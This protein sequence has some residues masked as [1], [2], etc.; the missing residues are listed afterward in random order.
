[1][2]NI[3]VSIFYASFLLTSGS[4]WAASK[5][6]ELPEEEL[7][8]DTALPMFDVTKV[9]RNRYVKTKGRFEVSG[10]IG[11]NMT[12]ALYNEVSFDLGLGYNF[13]ETHAANLFVFMFQDGLSSNG[14]DLQV[15]KG[16]GGSVVFDADLAPR[17]EMAYLADY[18]FTAWYGKVSVTKKAV[19]NLSLYGLLGVNSVDFGDSNA[20]GF[21]LGFGQKFYIGKSFAIRYDIRTLFYT[22][23]DP[24]NE[25]NP[26]SPNQSL[27]GGA[28]RSSDELGEVSYNPFM[29]NLGLSYVF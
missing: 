14:K 25:L 13:T 28:K 6:I 9:V 19:M 12:E 22:G 23:P 4:V 7:A 3:I 2:K 20:F 11:F 10:G 18:Q 26:P 27:N 8:R 29:F 16:L 21:H 15:G 1:M 17:P 5:A 24:A